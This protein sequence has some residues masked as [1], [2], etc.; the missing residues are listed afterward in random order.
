M[1]RVY[2]EMGR[3]LSLKC[4]PIE[5]QPGVLNTVSVPNQANQI[6]TES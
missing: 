1:H 3:T 6:I 5:I 4:V 2:L